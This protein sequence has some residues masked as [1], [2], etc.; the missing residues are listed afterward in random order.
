MAI[1]IRSDYTLAF[2]VQGVSVFVTDIHVD[3]YNDLRA[4]FLID[5]GIFKQYFENDAYQ[6][7]LDRGLKFYSDQNSF[8]EYKKQLET[9]IKDFREFFE[10]KMKGKRNLSADATETFFTYTVKL[11]KDY[12]RMNFEFT[13]K[14][15]SEQENNPI[16]KQNLA[17]MSQFK[18]EVRSFMNTVLF[19][20]EGFSNEFFKILGDQFKINSNILNDLT[21]QEILDLYNGAPINPVQI[22]RRQTAF[23]LNFDRSLM[24]E[25]K[26]AEHLLTLF[27]DVVTNKNMVRGTPASLGK[28][29]GKVKLITVDYTNFNALSR[30]ISKMNKGDILVAETTAPELI[31]ACRKASAIVTDVGGMLSHAAIVSREF[32]IPCI[33]GTENATQVFKDG[34]L[35]EVDANV[36]TV[37]K[38]G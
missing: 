8:M 34:D 32:G 11:C 1:P 21:Q 22:V 14:A 4:L 18:D 37:T 12:T 35:V 10:T 20:P 26:E 30:E 25:G 6:A 33:V 23:V 2:W 3:V 9:H 38:I 5:Q 15:F 29:T 27:R 17:L 7:A 28:A 19:E 36:G 13:D 16:I 24:L 31:V